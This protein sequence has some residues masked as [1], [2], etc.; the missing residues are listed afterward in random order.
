M[1][2]VGAFSIPP[3]T[4][5]RRHEHGSA[6][7][8]AVLAGGFVEREPSGWRDV[9]PG[10]IRVSGPARHD[11]DFGP[12]GARCLVVEVEDDALERL[13]ASRFL[14]EDGW[15]VRVARRLDAAVSSADPARGFAVPG[16]AA[17]LLAQVTRR[18]EG[19]AGPPPP[20][21]ARVRELLHDSAGVVPVA[22]LARE[23]GVHRVH[24][25]RTFREHHGVPV[26]GYARQLRLEAARRH[27]ARGLPLAQAALRAG[28]ADQSHLTRA[29]RASWGV[30]PGSLRDALHPFK[31]GASPARDRS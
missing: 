21:L 22:E 25:A 13:P 15:L 30:T 26:T 6:H 3:G 18:L 29:M 19:R 10:T 11:C 28:F 14:P 1:E 16:L 24:L 23:A 4:R 2:A 7:V 17:E 27:V 5:F 12:Q 31:T 8:V 20:W 9:N